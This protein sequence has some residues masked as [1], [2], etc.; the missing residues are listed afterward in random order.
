MSVLFEA[1]FYICIFFGLLFWRYV[2]RC[3]FMQSRPCLSFAVCFCYSNLMEDNARQFQQDPKP[4]IPLNYAAQRLLK[5]FF[6]H[7][8]WNVFRYVEHQCFRWN[9]AKIGAARMAFLFLERLWK[10]KSS[11]WICI[12]VPIATKNHILRRRKRMV[13]S[14][15][16]FHFNKPHPQHHL[17]NYIF[18]LSFYSAFFLSSVLFFSHSGIFSGIPQWCVGWLKHSSPPPLLVSSVDLLD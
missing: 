13:W 5:C 1:F 10:R 9:G 2:W 16:I 14:M 17:W 7:L 12:L 4:Q 18:F 11:I 15:C 8:T 3:V 6:L